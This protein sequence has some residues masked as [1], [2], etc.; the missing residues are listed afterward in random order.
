MDS[1]QARL[2]LHPPR[3]LATLLPYFPVTFLTFLLYL[4]LYASVYIA[5]LHFINIEPTASQVRNH[6]L[7]RNQK[8]HLERALACAFKETATLHCRS[9]V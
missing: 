8:A 3:P 7:Q 2:E 4:L 6:Y 9:N 1:F 5:Q